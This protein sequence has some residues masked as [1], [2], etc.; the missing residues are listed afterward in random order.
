MTKQHA[1]PIQSLSY[2]FFDIKEFFFGFQS[3]DKEGEP[4]I[5]SHSLND[6]YYWSDRYLKAKQDGGWSDEARVVND[7]KVGG[8]L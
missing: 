3:Y 1:T 2:K 7:G 4:L 8:K 6:C 5:L